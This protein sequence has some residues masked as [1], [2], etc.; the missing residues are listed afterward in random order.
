MEDYIRKYKELCICVPTL[1]IFDNPAM[2]LNFYNGLKPHVLPYI[3]LHQCQSLQELYKEARR[4]KHQSNAVYK[5]HNC[6]KDTKPRNKEHQTRGTTLPPNSEK[7]KPTTRTPKTNLRGPTTAVWKIEHTCDR[8]VPWK[9][10]HPT[11]KKSRGLDGKPPSPLDQPDLPTLSYCPKDVDKCPII[12]LPSQDPT[13]FISKQS[14]KLMSYPFHFRDYVGSALLDIE[15]DRTLINQQFV[16]KFKLPTNSLRVKHVVLADNR[17]IAIN[18]ET[19]P[20]S[21]AFEN[22]RLTLQGPILDL[23]SYNV[24]LGLD[25]LKRNSPRVDWPTSTLTIK[26]EGINHQIYPDTIYNLLKD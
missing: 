15:A 19:K 4:T 5:A 13:L 11:R 23:P 8:P 24:I 6:C 22:L 21:V 9:N 26:R 20:F 17:H 25:W 12:Q 7:G 16:T 10:I 3:N 14:N 18:L 2:M 1:M